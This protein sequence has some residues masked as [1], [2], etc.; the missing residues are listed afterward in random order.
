MAYGTI[1]FK[2]ASALTQE[3]IATVVARTGLTDLLPG[4]VL[5]QV[6]TAAARS[7][8]AIYIQLAAIL[9]SF[10]LDTASG[11]DLSQRALDYGTQR[12]AAQVST[13]SIT[14]SRAATAAANPATV[15]AGTQVSSSSG[16]ATYTTTSVASFA[17]A[18]TVSTSVGIVSTE[19]GST[20]NT[21]ANGV[22]LVN[23]AF[24]SPDLA[25]IACVNTAATINGADEET[26]ETL[27]ARL[28]ALIRG[29][30]RTSPHALLS[31]LR[32]N[33]ELADGRR[34]VSG[35]VVESLAVPGLV[36]VY[37]DDGSGN[38]GSV[39]SIVSESLVTSA[40]GGELRF[41]IAQPP[42]QISGGT[43]VITL[44]RTPNGAPAINLVLG[45]DYYLDE[46]TGTIHLVGAYAAGLT[47]LDAL[48]VSYTHYTGLI[49]ESQWYLDG[50]TSE[51]TEYPGGRAAGSRLRV[52]PPEKFV[53]AITVKTTVFAGFTKATVD[54]TVRTNLVAYVN[55]L[56]VG[57][58]IILAEL[59]DVAMAVEGLKDFLVTSPVPANPANNIAVNDGQIARIT[60]IT[61]L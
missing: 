19:T 33:I 51:L 45:T 12:L 23:T 42:V 20:Q 17:A 15:P 27:R 31:A 58:D 48:A 18:G 5:T 4:S 8:E 3:M 11:D 52:L 2:D 34:V 43:A 14:F 50:R 26:D 61:I 21:A 47:A 25:G 49:Q 55:G 59:Y 60:N 10:G 35:S 9:D 36:E 29:L 16:G 56:G 41:T 53:P 38:S 46:G 1:D 37:V 54:E 32:S 22:S 57:E 13:G 28:R 6:L 30:N 40:V 44:T 24:S 39:A 7:D